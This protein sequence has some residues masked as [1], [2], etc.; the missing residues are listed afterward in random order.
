MI[1][2]INNIYYVMFKVT[3]RYTANIY[4]FFVVAACIEVDEPLPS[5]NEVRIRLF[6][7]GVN[8]NETYIRTGTYSFYIPELPYTPGFDGAGVVDAIGEGVNHLKVGDRVFVAALLAKRNT[9]TYSQKV[10][11]DAN[12]VH[13]LPESI[14]YQEGASLGIPALTAYRALFHRAKIKLGENVLIHGASFPNGFFFWHCEFLI[15]PVIFKTSFI[16][17]A[18]SFTTAFITCSS[19]TSLQ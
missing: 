11:C 8:P 4:L 15:A 1:M 10:V 9:G 2:P 12:A 19:V 7:A 13:R 3:I 14:S 6:A 16:L 17:V 18:P 5:I